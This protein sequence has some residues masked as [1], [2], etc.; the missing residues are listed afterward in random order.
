MTDIV[1]DPSILNSISQIVTALGVILTAVSSIM[2]RRKLDRVDKKVD[3][4]VVVAAETKTEMVKRAEEVKEAAIAVNAEV[5]KEVHDAGV[6]AG[7]EI[8]NNGKH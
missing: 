6:A 3:R 8:A 1:I 5:V 2:N 7:K 4:A